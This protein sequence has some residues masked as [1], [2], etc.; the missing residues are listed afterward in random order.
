[1]RGSARLDP[2]F[3]RPSR[4]PWRGVQKWLA[5]VFYMLSERYSLPMTGKVK[6][7]NESWSIPNTVLDIGLPS[8]MINTGGHISR[9]HKV[10]FF[11]ESERLIQIIDLYSFRLC[12]IEFNRHAQATHLQP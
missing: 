3:S 6:N 5:R 2:S 10:E 8:V 12:N 11:L 7:S 4:Q 9:V 1:M